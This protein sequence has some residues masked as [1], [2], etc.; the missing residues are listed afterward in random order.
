MI[1]SR[2]KSDYK[3]MMCNNMVRNC[4]ISQHNVSNARTM[5][6]PQLA[7]VRGKTTRIKLEPVV[8]EY[9]AIPRDFIVRIKKITLS[10]DVFFV[11]VIT[12]LLT[13]S[14]QIKFVTVK[15]TPSCTAKHLSIHVKRVLRV[16]HHAGFTV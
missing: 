2:S 14:C 9:V 11:D 4:P 15:H 10:A 7:G 1:G 13:L 16:Y 5:F 3:T 6:C 12:F 8:K